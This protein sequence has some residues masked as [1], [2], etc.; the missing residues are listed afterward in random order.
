MAHGSSTRQLAS[1][2]AY[3]TELE[4]RQ[5]ALTTHPVYAAVT[6]ASALKTF[7][8]AHVYA[9]WD[10]MCLV[11]ELQRRFTSVEGPYWTPPQDTVAARLINEIVLGEETDAFDGR[12]PA[13]HFALYLEAMEE[14]G[15]DTEPVRRFIDLV[16]QG[17]EPVPALRALNTSEYVTTFV[18]DTLSYLS[19]PDHVLAAVFLH[20]RESLIPEMFPCLVDAKSSGGVANASLL[21]LY[22]ERHIEVDGEEHGPMATAL[23]QRLCGRD[24]AKENDVLEAGIRALESRERLWDGIADAISTS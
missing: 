22:L 21:R 18:G 7:M 3:K 6:H 4:R 19:S 16:R 2:A 11:K 20:G 23:L 24:K 12:A 8:E 15:A 17:R 1:Q 13:S 10:F 14:V 9:V 5:K